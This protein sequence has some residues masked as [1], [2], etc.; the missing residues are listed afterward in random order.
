MKFVNKEMAGTTEDYHQICSNALKKKTVKVPKYSRKKNW[1]KIIKG[2]G[3]KKGNN[4]NI[5][6]IVIIT[7]RAIIQF[8]CIHCMRL[9]K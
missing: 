5:R 6:N 7:D 3:G 2:K 4:I 9:V 1:R 8:E